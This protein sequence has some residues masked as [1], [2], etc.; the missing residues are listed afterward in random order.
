MQPPALWG[1]VL[2]PLGTWGHH[3]GTWVDR[4]RSEAP[5]PSVCWEKAGLPLSRVSLITTGLSSSWLPVKG[6][7]FISLHMKRNEDNNV[8]QNSSSS[9]KNYYQ[10]VGA[11]LIGF[12]L[13]HRVA[14]AGSSCTQP[15][16]PR[17]CGTANELCSSTG[18]WTDLP[19]DEHTVLLSAAPGSSAGS[20]A[21]QQ[22]GGAGAVARGAAVRRCRCS[23]LGVQR[24]RRCNSAEV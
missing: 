13:Q 16:S 11:L 10:G 8:F 2:L 15:R 18:F 24:C 4:R 14:A 20:A 22:T 1:S 7:L 5:N 3:G 6:K 19:E 9:P 23:S 12:V 21:V 17:L